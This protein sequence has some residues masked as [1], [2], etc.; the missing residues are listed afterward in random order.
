MVLL[1]VNE[2]RPPLQAMVK[3]SKKLYAFLGIAN[4]IKNPEIKRGIM[5]IFP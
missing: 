2:P 4:L 1:K 3:C 5:E